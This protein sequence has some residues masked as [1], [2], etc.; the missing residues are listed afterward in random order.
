MTSHSGKKTIAIHILPN[1]SISKGNQTI[2]VGQLLEYNIRNTFLENHTQNAVFSDPFLK[3]K[4]E[5]ISGS[6]F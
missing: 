5:R 1:I 3:I 2:K 4:I 6:I